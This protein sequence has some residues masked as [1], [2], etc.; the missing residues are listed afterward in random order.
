MSGP[1]VLP[2][3]AMAAAIGL[4]LLC[5]AALVVVGTRNHDTDTGAGAVLGV[6]APFVIALAG[7]WAVPFVHRRAVSTTAGV[8]VVAITVV[9]GMV[10]RRA[11]FDRGTAAAFV[12][13]ATVFLAVTMLGWRA[14][15]SRRLRTRA[16]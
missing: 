14:M 1:I 9:V 2:R 7:A 4:D 8:A 15:L 5:V 12:I 6:A 3:R 13:V 11:V 16:A 10:L